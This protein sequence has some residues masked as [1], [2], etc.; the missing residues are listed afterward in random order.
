MISASAG[1]IATMMEGELLSGTPNAR[2][3]GVSINSRTMVEGNLFFCLRGDRF[4]GHDF[5]SEGLKN[6]AAGIVLSGNRDIPPFPAGPSGIHSAFFIRVKD[7]LTALQMLAQKIRELSNIRVVAVTGTNGKSSAK[8]MIAAVIGKKFKTLKNQGNLNNHIGLPLTLMEL[9]KDHEIAVLEMGMSAE[10][11]IK[12]L[13]EIARPNIG[14]I[15]NISP[16]HLE[17]LKTLKNVQRAKGELFDALR[18]QDLAVVNTDDPLVLELAQK[19]KAKKITIGINNPADIWAENIHPRAKQGY[20][21]K[22]HIQGQTLDV[23]LPFLGRCNIYNA[24]TAFAVG[25][26]LGMRPEEMKSGLGQCQ[27]PPQRQEYFE[28]DGVAF[29]NDAYNANPQSMREAIKTLEG[30]QTSGR[31]FFVMGEMLELA[32]LARSEHSR[33]GAEIARS[34]IDFLATVGEIPALTAEAA[35]KEG[36]SPDHVCAFND[37]PTVTAFLKDHV[38]TGDCVLIKGSRGAKMERVI[39]NYFQE[40]SI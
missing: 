31:K 2:F 28:R 11:E 36:M 9:E 14:L 4:D 16:A 22:L 40:A 19:L 1:E 18:P 25:S 6:K 10:G 5:I 39:Q 37:I 38:K 21:F 24:L 33:L 32:D 3:R 20:D 34:K 29:I 26:A 8:E 15:T 23:E 30:F 12:R 17:Q 27:L 7:T 35:R 13:A